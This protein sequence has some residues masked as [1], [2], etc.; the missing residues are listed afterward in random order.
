MC[1]RVALYSP[2]ARMAAFLEATAGAEFDV[3]DQRGWTEGHP[4]WNI[5]PQR[6]LL[7][8][9][10][11]HGARVIDRYR[12]GLVPGWS[13]DTK[14]GNR[15]FNARGETIAEKP[16]FRSAFAK[17]TCAIPIDLYYEWDHRP[18]R[19]RQAYCF[20]RIDNTPIILAGLYECWR[21]PDEPSS[22]V[23]ATCTVITT[24]PSIDTDEIHD[25]MP[26][27]LEPDDVETWINVS[28]HSTDERAL[29]LRPAPAGTLVHFGVGSAVGSIKNDGPALIEPDEPLTLL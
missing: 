19:N 5:G 20:K 17:R 2:P 28:D 6:D 1:G 4:S 13:K 23:L 11:H 27:V 25:R 15:L 12:W 7:G 18:G 8:V 14:I 21:D 9:T 16:S 26:V 29:L 22:K 24:T 3:N 10:E